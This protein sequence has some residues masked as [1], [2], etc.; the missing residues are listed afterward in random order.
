[1]RKLQTIILLATAELLVLFAVFGSP[2]LASTNPFGGVDCSQ[3]SGS[4][5]CSKQGGDPLTGSNGVI[6]K[7]AK[8]VAIVGGFIAVVVMVLAG[9]QFTISRGDSAATNKARET[10]IYAA[11]GLIVIVFSEQLITYIVSR[12]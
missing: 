10:M 5:V 2:A 8:L 11:V 4:P 1:M 12:V 6:V 3:A 9:I 7:A